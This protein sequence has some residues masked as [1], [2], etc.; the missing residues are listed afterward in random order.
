MVDGTGISV[1]TSEG[2]LS[3]MLRDSLE[4]LSSGERKVARTILANYPIAGLE[5]VAELAARAKVSPP[6][7]VRCVSR[8]GFSGYPE[9]QKRLMREAVSYTHLTLP[10][11]C[12][13]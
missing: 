11:M 13:V 6:T 2:T 3:E 10:T 4:V 9:F 12:Q 5:T 1:N 8:L 7:V